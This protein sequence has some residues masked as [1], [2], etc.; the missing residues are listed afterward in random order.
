MLDLSGR[1]DPM[2][3]VIHNSDVMTSVKL[4]KS[5]ASVLLAV[6]FQAQI[7]ENVKIPCHWPLWP[8]FYRTNGWTAILVKQIILNT[9]RPLCLFSFL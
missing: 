8:V 3:F 6:L 4:V 1:P 2:Y 7:K 5:T 9:V